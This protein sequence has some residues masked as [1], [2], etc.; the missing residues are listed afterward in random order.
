MLKNVVGE[1]KICER[2]K[3]ME[4]MIPFT[5]NPTDYDHTNFLLATSVVL[6][7]PSVM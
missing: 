4:K 6:C 5:E 7:L 2:V 3:I 1:N